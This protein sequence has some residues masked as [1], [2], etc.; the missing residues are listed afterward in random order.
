MDSFLEICG[1]VTDGWGF[2]MKASGRWRQVEKRKE[3][4]K[5][6]LF[7]SVQ[8]AESAV[9]AGKPFLHAGRTEIVAAARQVNE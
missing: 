6:L 3:A 9:G 2:G 1:I 8:S 7:R 5:E 4:D